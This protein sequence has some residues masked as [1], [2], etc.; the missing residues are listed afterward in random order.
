VYAFARTAD[1]FADE[2]T[3]SA[4]ERLA[5]LD[6]WESGL[7]RCFRGE[8]DHPVFVALAETI[9]R[10]GMPLKPFA[11]L[12]VAFR[13]DV[14]R[15]RFPTF[16]DLLDY[17][18]HSA[19][20]IGQLVLHIFSGVTD[21]TIHLSDN[22]CTALQ[23][24]NFWQDVSIDWAKRRL[25]IPVEDIERF[26]YTEDGLTRGIYNKRFRSLLEFQVERTRMYF[27]AGRPLLDEAVNNLRFELRLTWLGG[28]TILK[29]I[30][31]ANF[32][33]LSARPAISTLDKAGIFM[34]ALAEGAR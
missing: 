21:R 31:Q 6:E 9:A 23:L 4:P 16:N 24:A 22:I 32:D 2:G 28:M 29:K 33:V 8:A 26:G 17:C 20:P 10:F 14:T 30:E 1:D 5:R 34:K 11:D 12:L 7:E 3:L 15:N 18:A 27:S 19:N 25:Y 13:W